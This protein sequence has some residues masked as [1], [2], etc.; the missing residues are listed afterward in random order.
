VKALKEWGQLA[1]I[2]ALLI[3]GAIVAW[4]VFGSIP[5]NCHNKLDPGFCITR[6]K[7]FHEDTPGQRFQA[8]RVVQFLV[9]T[10]ER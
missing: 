2:V 9:A 1:G 4:V 7:R 10:T 8:P 6:H 3:V 5:P